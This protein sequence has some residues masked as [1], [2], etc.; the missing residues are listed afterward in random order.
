MTEHTAH[1]LH[2][3]DG[4]D[5]TY[6]LRKYVGTLKLVRTDTML[7]QY[8]AIDSTAPIPLFIIV[9]LFTQSK[10]KSCNPKA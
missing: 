9:A 4:T 5:E 10:L 3:H 2:K 8:V 7:L 6:P 1:Q